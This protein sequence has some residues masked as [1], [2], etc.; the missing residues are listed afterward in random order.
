MSIA[1]LT[2]AGHPTHLRLDQLLALGRSHA[3]GLDARCTTRLPFRLLMDLLQRAATQVLTSALTRHERARTCVVH[4]AVNGPH[5]RARS[6]PDA[7]SGSVYGA[8]K[9][10]A[11]SVMLCRPVSTWPARR[12]SNA[13]SSATLTVRSYQPNRSDNGMAIEMA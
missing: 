3:P 13:G 5:E 11:G 9:P 10:I 1:G 6:A 7:S 8:G 4:L 12:H 2:Q